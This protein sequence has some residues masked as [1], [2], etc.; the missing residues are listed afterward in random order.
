MP[1]ASQP[2]APPDGNGLFVVS[3]ETDV[4]CAG[5]VETA[6]LLLG[7]DTACW[8]DEARRVSRFEWFFSSG[9]EAES[10][11]ERLRARLSCLE[12]DCPWTGAVRQMQNADWRESW[13]QFF[14]AEQVSERII[15]KPPWESVSAPPG[16]VVVEIDPGMSFGT[17]QHFAT[18]SCLRLIDM[19]SRNRAGASFLDMGCGSGILAI[20]AV[21][22]GLRGVTAVDHDPDAVR[23]TRENAERNGVE[24]DIAGITESL[25]GLSLTGQFDIVA[26][27]LQAD[28][29]TR[30]AKRLT[31]VLAD[32]AEARLI[33]SGVLCEQ[34]DDVRGTFE[35]IGFAEKDLLSGPE[36]IAAGLGRG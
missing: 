23:T 27:N 10:D 15:V 3:V 32:T 7:I 18:R 31:N 25:D 8:T 33:I 13:K 20:A 1:P 28:T 4:A 16:V 35:Q 5:T 11:L 24:R 29:L 2:H 30:H 34:Y 36:W 19:Y 22:L 14:R 12:Y 6:L 17:G 9:A 21:K 26:A